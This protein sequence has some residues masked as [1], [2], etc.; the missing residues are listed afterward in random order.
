MTIK[1]ITILYVEDE[2]GIRDN[3]TSILSHFCDKIITA[4]N[5][6]E[7]LELYEQCKPDIIVS[8]IRMP[9]MDG[10][11]MVKAIREIEPKI[12]ILFT[13]AY[14][15]SQY[16]LDAIELQVDGYIL[17]PIDLDKLATKIQK[18]KDNILLKDK[19]KK[20]Q[21]QLIQSEK[22]ASLGEM[23]G[24]IAHQWR[25]PLSIISTLATG[26]KIQ[27]EYNMLTDEKFMKNMDIINDNA[28]Y[29]SKTI[30]DFKNFIKGDKEKVKFN[31]TDI[32]N[33]FLHIVQGTIINNHIKLITNLQDDIVLKS[34]PHELSQCLINIFNNAK[35]ILEDKDDS[36]KLIFI[37]TSVINDYAVIT[38]CDTGEGI[39]DTIKDKIFEP[40]FTTKHQ[41]KGTGLGLS[42][43]YNF[44]VRNMDGT[45][46]V[47]NIDFSYNY[48]DYTGAKFTIKLPIYNQKNE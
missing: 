34:Y 23:I 17:K 1:N 30:E 47:D 15:E 29:L 40:Y 10:I 7:G 14:S 20:Q 41:S 26:S 24:N 28:Q 35:D 6:Q 3:L 4:S 12:H 9:K 16:F 32:I 33:E 36:D 45:I 22:M 46:Y 18:I 44:I 39:D 38:I 27:K 5:G 48:K 13:T 37:T 2:Q 43:V 11:E 21:V 25:Q 19:Y 8:D 31:L 42:M